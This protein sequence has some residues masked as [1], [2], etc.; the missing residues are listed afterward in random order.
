MFRY[1]NALFFFT[2][3]SLHQCSVFRLSF[4]LY[5][6][7]CK[8]LQHISHSNS[9]ARM[10][11]FFFFPFR[12]SNCCV[13]FV[14]VVVVLIH[15]LLLR[16]TLNSICFHFHCIHFCFAFI[17]FFLSPS[18]NFIVTRFSTLSFIVNV[19]CKFAC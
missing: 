12:K 18:P 15:L 8:L 6:N 7:G 19:R 17:L 11:Q 13:Y 10:P 16:F 2:S 4:S 9:A 5:H 3:S 1:F 14:V